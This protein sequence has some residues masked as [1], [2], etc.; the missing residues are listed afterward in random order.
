MVWP[1]D[2]RSAALKCNCEPRAL[3]PSSR[4]RVK[5]SEVLHVLGTGVMVGTS[6]TLRVAQPPSP[7]GP[8]GVQV[9]QQNPVS[10]REEG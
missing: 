6:P 7:E 4:M 10:A 2:A 8:R 1:Q 5:R 3:T 9:I